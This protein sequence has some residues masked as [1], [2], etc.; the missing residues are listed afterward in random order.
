MVSSLFGD[1]LLLDPGGR[2]SLVMDSVELLVLKTGPGTQKVLNKH[3]KVSEW[4]TCGL[5]LDGQQGMI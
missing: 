2:K 1:S 4:L 5:Q 3:C